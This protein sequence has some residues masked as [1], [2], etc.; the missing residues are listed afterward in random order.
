M[1]NFSITDK[2][3][4]ASIFLSVIIIVIVASYSFLRARDAILSRSFDQLISVRVIKKNQLEDFFQN[5]TKEV[6]LV[7]SSTDIQH[8]SE[9]LNRST[10]IDCVKPESKFVNAISKNNFNQ[11]ILLSES[12]SIGVL[13]SR[14]T[15]TYCSID[16]FDS[17]TN[18][19]PYSQTPVIT[20][21]IHC[22]KK[23]EHRILVSTNLKD[24]S[25][26]LFFEIDLNKIDSIMLEQ[27]LCWRTWLFGRVIPCR[28]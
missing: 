19:L 8:I 23:P 16:F 27:G 1:R 28:K 24:N 26:T 10:L 22:E 5:I 9:C 2:L 4:L 18:T 13:Y 6:N 7:S 25:G 12:N 21:I 11:I 17:L 14:N 15:N 20:E 3:I